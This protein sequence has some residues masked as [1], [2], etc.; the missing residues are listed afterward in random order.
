MRIKKVTTDVVSGTTDMHINQKSSGEQAAD[1][2]AVTAH[3][4]AI[5]HINR[6]IMSLSSIAGQDIVAK[7]SIAN[8][9]VVLLD[10]Q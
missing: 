9:S 1:K 6:A 5:G 8:L 4:E 2:S 7:E 10:L 3:S